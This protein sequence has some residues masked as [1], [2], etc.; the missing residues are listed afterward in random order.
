MVPA[1]ILMPLSNLAV[2]IVC[3]FFF[4]VGHP[5]EFVSYLVWCLLALVFLFQ[6]VSLEGYFSKNIPKEIRGVL[7]GFL[8]FCGLI[9]KSI[10]FKLGGELFSTGR[11]FPFLMIGICNFVFVIFLVIMITFGLFGKTPNRM[12]IH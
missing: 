4:F 9:G 10:A 2:G 7:V 8:S 11:P 6:G 12:V 5:G 1:K 3:C